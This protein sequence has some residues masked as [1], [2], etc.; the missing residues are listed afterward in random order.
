[1]SELWKCECGN[2]NSGGSY[3]IYCGKNKPVES[4]INNGN[5]DIIRA[6]VVNDDS[7]AVVAIA[8]DLDNPVE[9]EQE[10]ELLNELKEKE[11]AGLTRK[12]YL[13]LFKKRGVISIAVLLF[14]LC[15]LTVIRTIIAF[16]GQ[17]PLSGVKN[18]LL[19]VVYFALAFGLSRVYMRAKT[20][21]Y[22]D[23]CSLSL[24]RWASFAKF[25]VL[26]LAVAVILLALFVVIGGGDFVFYN[27]DLYHFFA[28]VENDDLP[29]D[30]RAGYNFAI[31]ILICVI[32]LLP[33]V[34]VNMLLIQKPF[35]KI[36]N[37]VKR[38]ERIVKKYV[39]TAVLMFIL[40][41]HYMCVMEYQLT[42]VSLIVVLLT[43]NLN[44]FGS[45]MVA[46][47]NLFLFASLCSALQAAV[48][49]IGGILFLKTGKI[50]AEVAKEEKL[51]DDKTL[52]DYPESAAFKG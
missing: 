38:D 26:I 20:D 13:K 41:A 15:G 16:V 33:F 12:N 19:C 43:N 49:I 18:A 6:N 25:I 29:F 8:S 48:C 35:G 31:F 14:I 52:A 46:A 22:V 28:S 45:G 10:S 50:P 47:L 7:D 44:Y 40:A 37:M 24:A 17:M 23:S 36:T 5:V 1:M 11:K 21:N 51:I 9:N 4:D 2:V 42:A 30:E 34:V 3:C 32:V 39:F 27:D